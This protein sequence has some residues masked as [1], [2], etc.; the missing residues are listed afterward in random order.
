MNTEITLAEAL[1]RRKEINQLLDRMRPISD[2]S[3]KLF[4]TRVKRQSVNESTDNIVGHVPRI[5]AEQVDAYFNYYARQLR[6]VD[7]VIQRANWDTKLSI[8]ATIMED[9]KG[10]DFPKDT[11]ENASVGE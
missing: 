2:V 4:V 9:F 7:A 6:L 5:S 3:E 8:K 11:H 1:L 10:E